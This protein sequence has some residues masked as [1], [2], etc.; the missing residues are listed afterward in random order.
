MTQ[1]KCS[2][3]F[4]AR[5]KSPRNAVI[6]IV[7]KMSPLPKCTLCLFHFEYLG[8]FG[9]ASQQ[10][11]TSLG[12]VSVHQRPRSGGEGERVRGSP[13]PSQLPPVPLGSYSHPTALALGATGPVD[14]WMGR[15]GGDDITTL[16]LPAPAPVY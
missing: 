6:I 10:E 7:Q 16:S 12:E 5:N 1:V 9:N 15:N 3:R 14:S 4:P 2:A 8:D 11:A 13:G